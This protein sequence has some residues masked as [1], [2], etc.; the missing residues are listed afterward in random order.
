VPTPAQPELSE[1][2]DAAFTYLLKLT[3][4]EIKKMAK[5]RGGAG[6]IGCSKP[7]NSF[8]GVATKAAP[9]SVKVLQEKSVAGFK[10][11]VLSADS[12]KA[13]LDWLKTNGYAFS[14]EVEAWA[15]PYV[16]GGWKFTALKMEK[17]KSDKQNPNL[18]AAA[19]RISFKTDK[20]LFPYREP[21]PKQMASSLGAS[22]R[23][24]RIYFLSDKRYDGNLTPEVDWTGRAVWSNKLGAE[25]R[26]QTIEHLKLPEASGPAD[27]WLTE[28]EDDW[29]YRV[30]PADLYFTLSQD[31]TTLKRPAIVEYVSTALPTDVMFCALGVFVLAPP[32]VRRL[33]RARE[34]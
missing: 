33:R 31:Q 15:K 13:L 30:A 6:C 9:A 24:L 12:T 1:S 7:E 29:P 25:Q 4:P 19:L 21:D 28:F 18:S 11:T 5:P 16:E 17:G 23:L 2:G 22:H 34:Q 10:A 14:P 27:F 3:E 32:L 26:M 8:E 20:P